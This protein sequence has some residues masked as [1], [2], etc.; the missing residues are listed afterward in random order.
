MNERPN[1]THDQIGGHTRRAHGRWA[2]QPR[3][4]QPSGRAQAAHGRQ[5]RKPC[6]GR[7]RVKATRRAARADAERAPQP[8]AR[9]NRRPCHG[10]A[11][12]VEGPSARVPAG[13]P[14]TGQVQSLSAETVRAPRSCDGEGIG[15]C[16]GVRTRAPTA[17]EVETRSRIVGGT[18]GEGSTTR[19]PAEAARAD[20]RMRSSSAE[21]VRASLDRDAEGFGA[22][23]E[24]GTRLPISGLCVRASVG[25]FWLLRCG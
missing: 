18:R 5:L 22:C 9:P 24:L 8:Y 10:N 25:A 15:A 16:G 3:G 14:R 17:R 2:T 21:S 12:L 1:R 19:V 7:A 11:R 20:G 4:R 23:S 13:D 6:A